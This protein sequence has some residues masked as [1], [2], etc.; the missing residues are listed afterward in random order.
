V[1]YD[2]GQIEKEQISLEARVVYDLL[3]SQ[4]PKLHRPGP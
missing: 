4:Q 3:V 2:V 1:D